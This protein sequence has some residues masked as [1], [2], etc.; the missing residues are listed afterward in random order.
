MSWAAVNHVLDAWPGS[1][2]VDWT[3]IA[4]VA[5]VLFVFA[6]PIAYVLARILP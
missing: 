4:I 2:A 1:E 6:K 5:V 3:V